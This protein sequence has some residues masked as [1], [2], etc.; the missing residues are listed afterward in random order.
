MN[1]QKRILVV[2]DNPTNLFLFE[3]LLND[4]YELTMAESGETALAKLRDFDPDLV[5]LDIMMPGISG[6]DVCREIRRIDAD[7]H[8]KIIMVSAKNTT[9]D[10]LDGYRAGAD[11]YITKPFNEDELHAKLNVYLRLKSVEELDNYKTEIMSILCH[12][13]RTPLNGVIGPVEM[14]I[15]ENEGMSAAERLEWLNV[16]SASADRL[17][18]FI[19]KSLL[20]SRIRGEGLELVPQTVPLIDLAESAVNKLTAAAAEAKV[21]IEIDDQEA[22]AVDVDPDHLSQVVESIVENAINHSEK[23]Q[24]VTVTLHKSDSVESI[25]VRDHGPGIAENRLEKIFEPFSRIGSRDYADGQCLSLH[26]AREIIQLHRGKIIVKSVLGDG[27]TFTVRLPTSK[28]L[29]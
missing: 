17:L 15:E 5:L 21:A 12:E 22:G 25:T 28:T 27:A 19:E 29:H 3:E 2:D 13:T 11:D 18:S 4:E 16:I 8:R 26:I 1:D 7:S 20:V 10:R 14:L 9:T 24:T 23:G 6:Y